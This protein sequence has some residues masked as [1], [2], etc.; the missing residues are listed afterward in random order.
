MLDLPEDWD[1]LHLAGH[2]PEGS[3][4]SDGVMLARL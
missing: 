4:I 1:C 3:L 2:S